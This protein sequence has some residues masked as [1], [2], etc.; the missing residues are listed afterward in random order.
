MT[1]MLSRVAHSTEVPSVTPVSWP[2]LAEVGQ[3]PADTRELDE[4]RS[5]LAAT[6]E[7]LRIARGRIAELE[8]T[9]AEAEAEAH[10]KG[11]L[12]GTQAA[13]QAADAE[14]KILLERI[15]RAIADVAGMRTRIR[16]DA[17]ADLVKLSLTIA[18]RI[19]H[20]EL[21]VD[22]DALLGVVRSALT[23]M[24][25]GELIKVRL[26]P[27]TVSTVRFQLESLKI[28]STV[29]IEADPSLEPGDLFLETSGGML[30][31]SIDTQLREV[32]R[33]FCDRFQN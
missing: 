4:I 26:H 8:G 16:R 29:E 9:H 24:T 27:A 31:A 13:R 23:K 18:R 3:G 30:D 28:P 10:R 19:T 1:G 2:N 6:L 14:Q 21:S 17:E 15:S 22:P 25:V 12:E 20:R 32:E 11:L 5:T 7:E 33:G